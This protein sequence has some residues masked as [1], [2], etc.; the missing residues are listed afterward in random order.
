[1]Y[2]DYGDEEEEVE[3]ETI[4]RKPQREVVEDLDV[5]LPFSF[6]NSIHEANNQTPHS[7][8]K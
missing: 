4:N 7:N 8:F 2:G 5:S 6:T 3:E 1:M